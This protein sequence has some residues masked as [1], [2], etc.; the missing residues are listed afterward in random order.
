MENLIQEAA[1]R[2]VESLMEHSCEEFQ[3]A[4]EIYLRDRRDLDALEQRYLEL[5][6]SNQQRQIINDYIAC[7]ESLKNRE[8][9]LAYL[10]GQRDG[11]KLN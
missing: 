6:L 3:Q 10:A 2:V 11:R 7:F 5:C 4:D 8:K 1:E 9:E